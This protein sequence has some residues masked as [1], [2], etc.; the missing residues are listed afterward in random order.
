MRKA[1]TLIELVFVIV[2]IGIL[3]AVII[4]RINSDNVSEKAID[5][6]SKIRY[7]QHLA[8]VDDKFDADAV[9]WYRNRWRIVFSD[10]DNLKYSIAHHNFANGV[11]G[12][13]TYAKDTLDTTAT[14]EDIELKGIT[15]VTLTVAPASAGA[16]GSCAGQTEITFDHLGRPH[17]GDIADDAAAYTSGQLMSVTCIIT[18]TNGTETAII[19]I[20]PE[21]GYVRRILL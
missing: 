3:S 11:A 17:V 9:N 14:I 12:A 7:T 5:L 16:I 10:T 20:E 4:P 15:S 1:F 6:V 19:H 18:L 8:M 21:T 13:I 2:V